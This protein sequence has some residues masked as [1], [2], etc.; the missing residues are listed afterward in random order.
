MSDIAELIE[1]ID[2]KEWLDTEGIDWRATSGGDNLQVKECPFCGSNNWRVYISQVKKRGL[3]FKGSCLAKFNLFSFAKEH[4]HT[5]AK[6]VIRNFDAFIRGAGSSLR[7]V[8][9]R[10]SPPIAGEW[11]LPHSVILPTAEGYTHPDL[12][13]RHITLDTQELYALRFCENGWYRYT[14]PEG[15]RR[16]MCFDN[17][18]IIPVCDID[19]VV[20]TFLGRACWDVDEEKG[21]KRYLFPPVLPGSGRFLYGANLVRGKPHLVMGEGPFDTQAI[22]QSISGHPDFRT[23]G[24]IGS[25][26]LSVGHGSETGEDQ[27]AV[28][29]QLKRE[30]LES[31]TIMWDGEKRALLAGL[32]A[33][34]LLRKQGLIVR[35]ALLPPDKDP[36]EIST[37]EVRDAIFNAV[38]LTDSTYFQL[39]C[40]SPYR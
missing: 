15:K 19:G 2:L 1:K 11:E 7:T 13:A 31:V 33:G 3:C 18:I 17:R 23:Y 28:F 10:L 14:D 22:H 35:I 25:F 38:V 4:L 30:G 34:R 37:R 24:A 32:E 6:G 20:Q 26:G 29:R 36:N 39:R 9:A 5:D 8:V 12:T 40:A 27:L 21:E 16:G